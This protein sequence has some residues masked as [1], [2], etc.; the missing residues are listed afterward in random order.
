MILRRQALITQITDK[1][2]KVEGERRGGKGGDKPLNPPHKMLILPA[3]PI[4]KLDDPRYKE[5]D[6][7]ARITKPLTTI[8]CS[9]S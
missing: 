4:N 7:C 8:A 6:P 3:T 1:H 9:G 2:W 5:S